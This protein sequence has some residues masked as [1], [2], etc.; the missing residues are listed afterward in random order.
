MKKTLSIMA[1]AILMLTLSMGVVNATTDFK[2]ALTADS[3]RVDQGG[4]VVITVSLKDFTANET[5][6]NSLIAKLD[7]DRTVF[8]TVKQADFAAQNGWSAIT[9]NENEGGLATENASFMTENHEAF[10]ITLKVKAN[11]TIGNTTVTLKEINGSD[12][13]TDVYPADQKITLTIKAASGNTPAP[14]N[15]TPVKPANNTPAPTN[16]TTMPSTGVVDYILPTIAVVAVVGI[17]AYVR[18][19]RI[20][21]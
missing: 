21:K 8:E 9:Y 1:I 2:V 12:S 17:F 3:T 4:T 15:N 11:A 13:E 16:N 19:N 6:I 20:D 5:G 18:Y 7:Y 14:T 10:K